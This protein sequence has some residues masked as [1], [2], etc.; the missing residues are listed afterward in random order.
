MACNALLRYLSVFC[1]IVCSLSAHASIVR[2]VT[3]KTEYSADK[4]L[5][6]IGQ[7]PQP[8]TDLSVCAIAL[9]DDSPV[10]NV[11]ILF[12][13]QPSAGWVLSAASVN[14]N[15][16]GQAIITVHPTATSAQTI[17]KAR[18]VIGGKTYSATQTLKP[19]YDMCQTNTLTPAQSWGGGFSDAHHIRWKSN[20]SAFNAEYT[21]AFTAW[22]GGGH[23]G[24][25]QDV[26]NPEILIQ[27]TTDPT[28]QA[29]A[30]TSVAQNQ[31]YKYV[32]TNNS[33]WMN[34]DPITNGSPSPPKANS[35]YIQTV[36]THEI[37]HCLGLGHNPI[38]R[39]ALLWF[40][41]DTYFVCGTVAPTADEWGAFI[42]LY[43]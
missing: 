31:V 27:D 9:Q 20:N 12:D 33:Y 30:W 24:F 38:D 11:P 34:A 7:F 16:K 2:A 19:L 15:A 21:N 4:N 1:F 13:V 5:I 36:A 25:I 6:S 26:N 14:T 29:Y 8:Q 37:G 18:W 28:N 42:G 23:V 39:A 43:P 17:L 22:S 32:V 35:H 3:L 41:I 40:D 10:V